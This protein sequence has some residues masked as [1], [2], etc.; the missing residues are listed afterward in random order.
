VKEIELTQGQ[1]AR[2]DDEDYEW[3]SKWKWHASW[4]PHTLSYMAA[5]KTS[6]MPRRTLLMHRLILNAPDGMFVDH[7]DHDTLNNQRHNIRLATPLQNQFNRRKLRP[8]SSIHKGVC[9][10]QL[11]NKWRAEINV[12]GRKLHLGL[13]ANEEDAA[14]AY[15]EAAKKYQGE[16]AYLNEV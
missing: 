2:V 11:T 6:G 3:L 8:F 14:R 12:D 7:E 9:W 16:F 5:Y 15:N 13:F 1:V 10:H 4:Q